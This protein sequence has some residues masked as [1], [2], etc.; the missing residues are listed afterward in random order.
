METIRKLIPKKD[1][2]PEI[3]PAADLKQAIILRQALV[4][5]MTRIPQT[6][7]ILELEQVQKIYRNRSREAFLT[8]A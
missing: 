2:N 4:L 8:E 7:V 5:R 3:S 6:R 1:L